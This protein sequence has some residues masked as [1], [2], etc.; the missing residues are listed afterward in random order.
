MSG[1]ASDKTT[2]DRQHTMERLQH[3]LD[4]LHREHARACERVNE[5]EADISVICRQLRDLGQTDQ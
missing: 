4:L 2:S 3:T 1:P 5:I